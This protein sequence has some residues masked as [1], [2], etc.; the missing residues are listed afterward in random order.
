MTGLPH[1][2]QGVCVKSWIGN[3]QMLGLGGIL[4]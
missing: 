2:L 4:L 3:I 1:I